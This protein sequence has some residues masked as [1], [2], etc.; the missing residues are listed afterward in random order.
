MEREYLK[1]VGKQLLNLALAIIV[2]AI[3]QPLVKGEINPIVAIIAV[4]LYFI[5]TAIGG[6]LIKKGEGK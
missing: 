4:A 5:I 6:I 1:E 3:I 2:F